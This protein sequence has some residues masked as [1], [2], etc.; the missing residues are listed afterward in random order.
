M[1]QNKKG[2]C[3]RLYEISSLA[4]HWIQ[5][6]FKLMTIVFN[7]LQ[8]NGPGY[9]QTK[10]K[11]KTYQSTTRRSTAKG[12]TLNAP[13]NM[14]KIYGDCVFTHT[15]ASHMNNLSEY[16]RLAGDTRTFM[17]LLKH[18]T[19]DWLT[20]PKEFSKAQVLFNMCFIQLHAVSINFHYQFCKAP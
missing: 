3:T 13:F 10:L 2:Q 11:T 9:L 18:T 12:I 14:R 6:K 17:R 8:G 1:Y 4:T 20:A 16:I 15:A 19:S 5:T 7:T